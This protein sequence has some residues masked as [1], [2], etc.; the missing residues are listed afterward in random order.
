[1]SSTQF[2]KAYLGLCVTPLEEAPR[3]SAELGG[4]KIFFKRDDLTMVGLGGN[5]VRKLEYLLGDAL[6]QGADTVIT[7]ASVQSN[8]LRITAAACRKLG[9]RPVFFV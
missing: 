8:F 3:L 7:T 4:P 6:S 1:M 9:L 5:K 2:P